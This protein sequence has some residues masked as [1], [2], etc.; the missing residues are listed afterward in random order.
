M[1]LDFQG[2]AAEVIPFEC[3]ENWNGE[4]ASSSEHR[5]RYVA[6][7]EAAWLCHNA[8]PVLQCISYFFC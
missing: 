1:D 7:L 4:A 3:L 6:Y 8:R 2:F 5:E